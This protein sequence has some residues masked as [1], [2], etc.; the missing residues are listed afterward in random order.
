ME[1]CTVVEKER[2]FRR[3]DWFD[4]EEYFAV[5]SQNRL[6]NRSYRMQQQV[7]HIARRDAITKEEVQETARERDASLTNTQRKE[8]IKGNKELEL[9]KERQQHAWYP[10]NPSKPSPT[11]RK[12]P[13]NE[14]TEQFDI[15]R[16]AQE[17]LYGHK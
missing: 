3:W 16:S 9:Q 17:E 13:R 7:E 14:P 2:R 5:R 4:V 1:S 11:K 8:N 10:V 12:P 15:L 6:G